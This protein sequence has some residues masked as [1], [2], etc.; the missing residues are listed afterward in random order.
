MKNLFKFMLCLLVT[1]TTLVSCSEDDNNTGTSGFT[2]KLVDA[3]GDYEEVWVNVQAIEVIVDGE[4]TQYDVV[5]PGQYNLLTLVAGNFAALLDENIPSGRLSQIRLIL[6]ENDNELQ[7]EGETDRRALQTPS[8]QQTG[9]KLNVNYDLQPGVTYDFILD[10]N[11]EQSIVELGAGQG[12]ILKPVIRTVT[13]AESGAISGTVSPAM[14]ATVT[15]TDGVGTPVTANTDPETGEFL[16][17]GVP[18]GTYSV[19]IEPSVGDM[20]TV[21][22]VVVEIG[23]TTSMETVNL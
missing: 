10:F 2:V 11:V 17:Y 13:E 7:I 6:G 15:A 18:E 16:L 20:V 9:L 23:V 19:M 8:A 5:Q 4:S 21:T 3:P 14:A 22:D 12:Y 1:G